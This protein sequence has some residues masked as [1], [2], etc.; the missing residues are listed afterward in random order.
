MA[1]LVLGTLVWGSCPACPL[2]PPAPAQTSGE[3]DCCPPPAS[4]EK[5]QTP[6]QHKSDDAC[7][8]QIAAPDPY[9]ASSVQ[10]VDALPASTPAIV[11]TVEAIIAAPVLLDE[12]PTLHAPPDLYL[13][14]ATLLV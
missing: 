9:I 14:N 4:P 8:G 3:H 5:G 12:T 11:I 6:Q 7:T 2:F 10:A 1:F 13:Q